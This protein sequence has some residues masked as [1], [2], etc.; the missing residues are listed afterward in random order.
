M[1]ASFKYIDI[2]IDIDN[3]PILDN[4]PTARSHCYNYTR[5][6][7]R[8]MLKFNWPKYI[9]LRNAIAAEAVR[10]NMAEVVGCTDDGLILIKDIVEGNA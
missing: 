6:E 7:F 3:W 4:D 2:D 8:A 5:N 10:R 1:I 9:K